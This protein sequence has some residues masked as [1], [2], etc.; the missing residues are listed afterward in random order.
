MKV[1]NNFIFFGIIILMLFA[2]LIYYLNRTGDSNQSQNNNKQNN[3]PETSQSVSASA[4]PSSIANYP[5]TIY[6]TKIFDNH[7]YI[8]SKKTAEDEKLLFTDKDE[9]EQIK[10]IPSISFDGD[11]YAVMAKKEQAFTGTLY[12]ISAD[13]SGEK[14][15]LK[16]GFVTNANPAVS[17]DGTKTAYTLFSNAE[18]H[19]GFTLYISEADGANIIKIDEDSTNINY[20]CFSKDA[21]NIAY[22]KANKYLYVSDIDA[23]SQ[24]KIYE[25][26]NNN[27]ISGIS[28]SE[29]NIILTY[30]GAEAKIIA[31]N[32]SDKSVKELYKKSDASI[33]NSFSEANL[34]NY[35]YLNQNDHNIYINN[36]ND[37]KNI[38][39]E[40]TN[41]IQWLN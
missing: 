1:K 20:L 26:Q 19:Y 3:N 17:L 31:V 29:N 10:F 9:E 14:E 21:K 28:W 22:I 34:N 13:G 35:I 36:T 2:V 6:Y 25:M 12:K 15:K 30:S 40:V 41:I 39:N 33:G 23:K 7:Y 27:T 8:Y 5:G 18:A 11:I 32:I 37:Q 16:D 38:I 24:T 4:N